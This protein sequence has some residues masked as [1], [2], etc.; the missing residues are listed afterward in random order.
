MQVPIA[1]VERAIDDPID[2]APLR[3]Q[4][5]RLVSIDRI[6]DTGAASMLAER[7]NV[8]RF[9]PASAGH[10]LRRTEP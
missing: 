6:A 4:R 3:G 1:Q 7:G 9:A 2:Q 8:E 10:R 5:E